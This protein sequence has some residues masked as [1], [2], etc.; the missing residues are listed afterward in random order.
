MTNLKGNHD[1]GVFMKAV[2]SNVSNDNE[3]LIKAPQG[4]EY[5]RGQ[6]FALSSLLEDVNTAPEKLAKARLPKT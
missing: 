4:D 5:L 2:A 6:V 1:F 3:R